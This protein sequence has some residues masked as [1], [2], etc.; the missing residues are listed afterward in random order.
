MERSLKKRG[1]IASAKVVLGLG[2]AI[3]G[4][5]TAIFTYQSYFE[6]SSHAEASHRSLKEAQELGDAML[7]ERIDRQE[8]RIEKKLE[9]QDKKLDTINRK[10]DRIIRRR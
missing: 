9:N 2:A 5:L 1:L 10:L 6:T 4:L 7:H 8:R 3:F